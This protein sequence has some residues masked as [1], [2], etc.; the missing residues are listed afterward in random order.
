MISNFQH[1]AVHHERSYDRHLRTELDVLAD[2][3][4]PSPKTKTKGKETGGGGDFSHTTA[5]L[6]SPATVALNL[7][8]FGWKFLLRQRSC[9]DGLTTICIR[10]SLIDAAPFAAMLF[11][12]SWPGTA[13]G[14]RLG[15]LRQPRWRAH[16]NEPGC[17]VGAH[18]HAL[19]RGDGDC[20]GEPEPESPENAMLPSASVVS[21]G[22]LPP[23]GEG[24]VCIYCGPEGAR[25][26]GHD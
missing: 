14:P 20:G 12:S 7:V 13:A 17:V 1:A 24:V 9:L 4:A 18:R 21:G 19:P 3:G 10:S 8:G 26:V 15:A 5:R 16:R 11:A 2:H 23:E 6:R 22:F 25:H